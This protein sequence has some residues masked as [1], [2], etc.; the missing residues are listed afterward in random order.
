M[1]KNYKVLWVLVGLLIVGFVY[2]I[3]WDNKQV[4]VVNEQGQI[5]KELGAVPSALNVGPELGIN[6]LQTQVI[7]GSFTHSGAT[8][9]ST[10]VD[11]RNPFPGTSTI[12]FFTIRN[13]GVSSTTYNFECGPASDKNTTT[14]ISRFLAVG[15]IATS[16]NFGVVTNKMATSSSNLFGSMT[17]ELGFGEKVNISGGDSGRFKCIAAKTPTSDTDRIAT[18]TAQSTFQLEWRARLLYGQ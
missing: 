13:V 9:S 8:A 17:G 14:L 7:S 1:E 15:S 5:V 4:I 6:G 18:T 12:D 2:L 11:F 10:L 16:T 3:V